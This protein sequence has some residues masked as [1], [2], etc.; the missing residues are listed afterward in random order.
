MRQRGI[1]LLL[2]LSVLLLMSG[3][4]TTSYYHWSEIYDILATN[5]K[6]KLEK[7]LLLGAEELLLTA[8]VENT[9]INKDSLPVDFF[10][11]SKRIIINDRDVHYKIFDKINCFNIRSIENYLIDDKENEM[12]SWRVFENIL[13]GVDITVSKLNNIV[14]N[15]NYYFQSSS[16][17]ESN[18][19]KYSDSSIKESAADNLIE[20]LF[21]INSDVFLPIAPLLCAR[22]DNTLLININMLE[23]RHSKFIQAISMDIVTETDIVRTILSKPDDGWHN[24]QSFFES[25][26][27]NSVIE[28]NDIQKLREIIMSH[29]SHDRY[30]ISLAFW[31]DNEDEYPQLTSFIHVK[32]KGITVLQRR[33]GISG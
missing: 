19:D 16:S 20:T 27:S 13:R 10:T 11:Y 31:L 9:L 8:I 29:F 4:V 28:K 14:E 6:R 22:N 24:V 23:I 12:Y 26:I 18:P 21:N 17:T 33:F 30:F 2:V 32:Q 7:W 25:L 3:M 5:K 1:A 15:L